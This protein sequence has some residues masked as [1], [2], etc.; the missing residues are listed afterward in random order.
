MQVHPGRAEWIILKLIHCVLYIWTFDLNQR[1][2][3]PEH[4]PLTSSSSTAWKGRVYHTKSHCGLCI[5]TFDHN[6]KWFRAYFY[7]YFT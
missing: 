1:N 4:I 3:C 6:Q 2:T 7:H 5:W